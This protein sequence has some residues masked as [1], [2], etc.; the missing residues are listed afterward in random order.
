MNPSSFIQ[1]SFQSFRPFSA[2]YDNVVAPEREK[3]VVHDVVFQLSILEVLPPFTSDDYR[4]GSRICAPTSS[5]A[6]RVSEVL[7]WRVALYMNTRAFFLPRCNLVSEYDAGE[8]PSATGPD[9]LP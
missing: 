1:P 7:A 2:P 4:T 5:R 8:D 6:P 9:F 3:E